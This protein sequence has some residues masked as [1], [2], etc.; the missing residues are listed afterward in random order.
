[1]KRGLAYK[2]AKYVQNFQAPGSQVSWAYNWASDMDPTYPSYLEFVPMLWG[3]S[4]GHTSSWVSN[5]NKA[6]ARGS[7]HLLAFNEPDNCG[8]GAC[9]TPQSAVDAYRTYMNPFAGKAYLGAPA[10]SNGPTGLPWL[11]QFLELCTGC[12]IDFVPIHWYD[13]ATN[14]AYFKSY[15]GQAVAVAESLRLSITEFNGAGTEAQQEAFL[16]TVLPW[17]DSQTYILQYAW[18][19]C[20]PTS[21]MGA[22]VDSSANPTKLGN[23]YAY[24]GF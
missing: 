17:L 22:L 24:T 10:V 14:E 16:T 3:N 15:I 6:L 9:M 19:W 11:T 18:F 5:V 2:S 8:G 20:D 1:P 23:V 12:H 21:K 13:K 7:S 4:T